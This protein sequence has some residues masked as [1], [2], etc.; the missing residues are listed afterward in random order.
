[1]K[2]T[3][4]FALAF[5]SLLS[6]CASD[7]IK[8][9]AGAE[10]VQLATANQVT[11]CTSLGKVSVN[12]L[13]KVGIYTRDMKAVDDNLLQLGRNEAANLGGNT[14]VKDHMPEYGKQVFA[15]YQCRR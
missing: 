13:A 9:V 2:T 11:G 8:P 12:V 3:Y 7:F 6:A 10:Q 15:V 4:A 5:S 1:M 14:L